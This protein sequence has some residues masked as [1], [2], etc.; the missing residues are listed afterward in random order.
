MSSSQT[1]GGPWEDSDGGKLDDGVT[2]AKAIWDK[3][4]NCNSAVG[5]QGENGVAMVTQDNRGTMTVAT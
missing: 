2:V 4:D 1:T 3:W 5:Q